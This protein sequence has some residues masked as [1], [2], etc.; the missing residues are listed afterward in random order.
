[1]PKSTAILGA[2]LAYLGGFLAA[3]ILWGPGRFW[4]G[5]R[6]VFPVPPE[7]LHQQLVTRLFVL[8]PAFVIIGAWIILS[9][10]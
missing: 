9:G 10:A 5:V 8:I 7:K 3:G 2:I 6:S 1:M 4:D